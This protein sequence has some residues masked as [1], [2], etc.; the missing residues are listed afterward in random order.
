M[1]DLFELKIED[2][3]ICIKLKKMN[4][5]VFSAASSFITQGDSLQAAEVMLRGLATEESKEQVEFICKDENF[6]L[7]LA[8]SSALD[9]LISIKS[10]SLKKI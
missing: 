4:R 3:D 7:L 1:K 6:E 9:E 2:T 5:T 10:A 8:A